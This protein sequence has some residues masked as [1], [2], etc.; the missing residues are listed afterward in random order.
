[1]APIPPDTGRVAGIKPSSAMKMAASEGLS[2]FSKYERGG[3]KRRL[4]LGQKIALD[5]PLKESE[6]RT[7]AGWHAR[8]WGD[9]DPESYRDY[10]D[11]GPDARY[12]AAK[13]LGGNEAFEEAIHL[14]DQFN[15]EMV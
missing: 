9:K 5:Q 10:S 3:S 6:W 4:E 11:G 1:M 8:N 7:I 14:V 15:Q 2:L 12:I 13:L